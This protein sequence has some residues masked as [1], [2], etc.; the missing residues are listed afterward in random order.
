M[1]L[2]VLKSNGENHDHHHHDHHHQNH[3]HCM[4]LKLTAEAKNAGLTDAA[5]YSK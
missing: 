3:A 4:D 1:E 5:T 2:E